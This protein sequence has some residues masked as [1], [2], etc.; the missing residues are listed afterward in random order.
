MMRSC[1][2]WRW[3][4]VRMKEGLR[5][6]GRYARDGCEPKRTLACA[7]SGA[8]VWT[9]GWATTPGSGGG[10]ALVRDRRELAMRRKY[11]GQTKRGQVAAG[12]CIPPAATG[13]APDA[14]ISLPVGATLVLG[15]ARR[16]NRRRCSRHFR[17]NIGVMG[18]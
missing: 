3:G 10:G 6:G 2:F 12:K 16:C 4:R 9:Q 7:K 1:G 13:G 8:A 5:G 15:A 14:A 17:R 18:R 11:S